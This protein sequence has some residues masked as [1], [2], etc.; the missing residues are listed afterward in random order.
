MRYTGT[1]ARGIRLPI[2]KQGDDLAEIVAD[3]VVGAT[4]AEGFVLRDNDVIGV[5]EGVVAISQ[6]NYATLE[7]LAEDVRQ[8]FP[9][10][11]VGVV[12][13][14]MSR[15]R[16]LNILKGI[17]KGADKVYVLLSYPFDEVGNPIMDIN[18]FDEVDD[19]LKMLE[20]KPVL[21]SRF[22]QEA[23]VFRHPFTGMNY[24]EMFQSVGEHV[25]VFISNDPRDILLLTPHVLV[26]EV[27]ARFR[28]KKRLQKA[29]AKSV[30]ML[31]DILASSVAGSGF[32]PEYGVLGS[33]FTSQGKLKL[34][35]RDCDAFIEAVRD[36]IKQRT[37]V[38]IEA[39]VYGDGAFKDPAHGIWELADPVVSPGY[40]E[41][42]GGQPNEI[43]LKYVADQELAGLS[44][45]EKEQALKSMIRKKGEA[46]AKA[47]SFDLG[48][49]PRKYAD[50]VGSLCDLISGSGD[51]GTPV[52]LVQGYFDD[53]ATQ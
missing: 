53:Y 27:H 15:N 20:T 29:G 32:H 10:G 5:T 1:L 25:E 48:T 21:A 12:F 35:P 24:I 9:S 52:V 16:F 43:K 13:P 18:R 49:T 11:E 30:F 37:G 40:S 6:G 36:K 39:M 38:R 41:M 14:L 51:K 50:L 19:T 47:G 3:C 28:T 23:G 33:N 44:D 17:S 34:F 7:Q 31:S 22:E 26:G 2:I 46:S 45:D 42:L 8:K 4:E